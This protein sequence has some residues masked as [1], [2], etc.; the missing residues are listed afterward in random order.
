MSELRLDYQLN[1]P[2]P[3]RGGVLLAVAL[4]A[5]GLTGAY[6]LRLTNQTAGWEAKLEQLGGSHKRKL[7]ASDRAGAA[8]AAE[9]AKEVR[10]A[11][12]VL[13]KLTMPWEDLFRAVETTASKDVTL[14]ALAPNTEKRMV[15]IYGEAKDFDAVLNYITLLENQKEFGTVYL[16]SHQIQQQDPEKPIRFTLQAAWKEKE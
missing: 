5:L 4:L 16:Q 1:R 12:E 10:Q 7:Q 8:A 6:Y 11:N 9:L 15:K 13:R 2:F 3:W 14:L